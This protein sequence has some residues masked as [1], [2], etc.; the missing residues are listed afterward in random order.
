MVV[1]LPFLAPSTAS[2][3]PRNT[4]DYFRHHL[5]AVSNALVN[6]EAIILLDAG[7]KLARDLTG[8]LG[9]A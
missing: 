7:A 4:A 2:I 1:R 8:T 3:N 5:A 6:A 9:A